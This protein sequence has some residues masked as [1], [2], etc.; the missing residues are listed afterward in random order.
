MEIQ[1][2]KDEIENYFLSYYPLKI[3]QGKDVKPDYINFTNKYS[4]Y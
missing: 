3:F 2:G 4:T 1:D